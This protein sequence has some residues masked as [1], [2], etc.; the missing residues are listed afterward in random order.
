M[1]NQAYLDQL[2][3]SNRPTKPSKFFELSSSKIFKFLA[4]AIGLFILLLIFGNVMSG[5]KNGKRQELIDFKAHLDG[6]NRTIDRYQGALK[7]SSLRSHSASLFTIISTTADATQTFIDANYKPDKDTKPSD[8]E[9]KL[10]DERD[11]DLYNAKINGLLDRTYARKF[12]YEIS[13]LMSDESK[14]V[15]QFD[16]AAFKSAI[17]SSYNSLSVLKDSFTSFS[18][19]K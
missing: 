15:K 4:A 5:I 13:V 19:A 17:Q 7:S 18:E 8:S 16:D 9:G 10:A 6:I 1:D 11:A 14:L 12:A 3:A 2:A